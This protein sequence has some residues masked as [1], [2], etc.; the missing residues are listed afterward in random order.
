MGPGSN[1]GHG[2]CGSSEP[3]SAS[4]SG[5]PMD[6]E[7]RAKELARRKEEAKRKRRKKKRT[8]SSLV[9]SCFQGK[10]QIMK[11]LIKFQITMQFKATVTCCYR[12]SYQ[13]FNA[14]HGHFKIT[15]YKIN[16]YYKIETDL[17]I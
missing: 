11:L 4:D 7:T 12:I 1:G 13:K 6:A 15:Y 3:G 14:L 17:C 8:G 16:V 9:S 10:T 2:A 5:E